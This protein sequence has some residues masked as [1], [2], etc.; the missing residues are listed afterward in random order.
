M[1]LSFN[2]VSIDL[3]SAADRNKLL[4]AVFSSI[5]LASLVCVVLMLFVFTI[6]KST[7]PRFIYGYFV[8]L[9]CMLLVAKS[10]KADHNTNK[11]GSMESNFSDWMGNTASSPKIISRVSHPSAIEG[12]SKK[13]GSSDRTYD[14]NTSAVDPDIEAWLSGD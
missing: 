9:G 13:E 8:S 7:A 6:N 10:L 5:P 4:S 1:T 14:P 12:M 11:I 3:S 2:N